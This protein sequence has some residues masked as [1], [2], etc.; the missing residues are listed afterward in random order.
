MVDSLKKIQTE[1]KFAEA[2]YRDFKSKK[3]G[4][5]PCCYTDLNDS[6]IK[7]QLCD[8]QD[9]DGSDVT[10]NCNVAYLNSE[11]LNVECT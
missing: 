3:Y 8:W 9:L 7:K 2:V 4:I 11:D 10:T 6:I 5:T 1:Q